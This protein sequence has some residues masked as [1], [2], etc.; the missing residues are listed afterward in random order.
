MYQYLDIFGYKLIRS[1]IATHFV[2]F[3]YLSVSDNLKKNIDFIDKILLLYL[4][5]V[6]PDF[7]SRQHVRVLRYLTSKPL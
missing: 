6:N 4:Y 5:I 1:F 7:K 3:F 2:F